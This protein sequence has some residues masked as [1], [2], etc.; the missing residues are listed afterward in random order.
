MAAA[1]AAPAV[2]ASVPAA[3]KGPCE[4]SHRG[5][6][7]VYA[8]AAAVAAPPLPAVG[9][10]SSSLIGGGG[11]TPLQWGSCLAAAA[12]AAPRWWQSP[13]PQRRRRR[14]AAGCA[15]MPSFWCGQSRVRPPLPLP[16]RGPPVGGGREDG[17]GG[18]GGVGA[19]GGEAGRGLPCSP[20]AVGRG[21][22]GRRGRQGGGGGGRRVDNEAGVRGSA[23]VATPLLAVD[24]GGR[25][26]ACRR[27]ACRRRPTRGPVA[28]FAIPLAADQGPRGRC[29][30]AGRMP[31]RAATAATWAA[32][33]PPATRHRQRRQRDCHAAGTPRHGA[34]P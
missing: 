27:R 24:R 32:P 8:A 16:C 10:G 30:A 15:H 21:G 12:A 18:V 19:V 11:C 33:T 34:W 29:P 22:R 3:A 6:P 20:V 5:A 31:R 17:Y 14:G 28:R 2:A 4:C 1:A 25:G 9:D 26:R 7:A 13:A 23:V